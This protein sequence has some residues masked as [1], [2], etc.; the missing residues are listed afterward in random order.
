M[1]QVNQAGWDRSL[2]VIIGA[3]MLAMGWLKLLPEPWDVALALFAF[4]PLVTGVSGWD[5]AYV[6]LGYRTDRSNPGQ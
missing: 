2:R 6:L 4:Y 3:L 5:P 1:F